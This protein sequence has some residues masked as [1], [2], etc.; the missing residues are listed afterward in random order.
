MTKRIKVKAW[1]SQPYDISP[2]S[3]YKKHTQ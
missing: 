1:F 2:A 3:I